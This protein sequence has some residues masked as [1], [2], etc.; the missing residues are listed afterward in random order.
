[1]K[2]WDNM[3]GIISFMLA[4]FHISLE[5]LLTFCLVTIH[6]FDMVLIALMPTCPKIYTRFS[7]NMIKN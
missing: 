5:P 1:M 4:F 7:G 3:L 2:Q 6:C